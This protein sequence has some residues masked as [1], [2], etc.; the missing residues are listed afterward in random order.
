MNLETRNFY[1]DQIR[2]KENNIRLQ[3]KDAPIAVTQQSG[4]LPELKDRPPAIP[5]KTSGG[6]ITQKQTK[7]CK[8]KVKALSPLIFIN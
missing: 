7:Y 3:T 8:I 4:T 2:V 6:S 5:V 1:E